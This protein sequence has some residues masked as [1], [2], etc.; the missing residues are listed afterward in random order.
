MLLQYNINN[1]LAS[2][3]G[4]QIHIPNHNSNIAYALSSLLKV[5]MK[6]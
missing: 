5:L 1:L 3:Y 6:S 4:L 2:K